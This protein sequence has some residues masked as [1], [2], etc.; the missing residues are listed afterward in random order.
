MDL[1]KSL[2]T[3]VLPLTVSILF[4]SRI[5]KRA[6]YENFKYETYFK[7]GLENVERFRDATSN[8]YFSLGLHQSLPLADEKLTKF[9]QIE[10]NTDSAIN[11]AFSLYCKQHSPLF[12][13]EIK[14][15]IDTLR[16]AMSILTVAQGIPF[17]HNKHEYDRARQIA[18]NKRVL[19]IELMERKLRIFNIPE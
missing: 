3:W 16:S 5:E 6:R 17:I 18:K 4:I 1:V 9:L 14:E 15:E 10:D 12:D 7:L 2:I 8:Y 19:I 13:Q 11:S